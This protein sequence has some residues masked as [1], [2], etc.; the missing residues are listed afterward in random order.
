MI[1]IYAIVQVT[2]QGRG[3]PQVLGFGAAAAALMATF[4][5]VESR[6][7]NPIMPLRIL[8]LRGLIGASAVRGFLVTG[9][10]STF[11]L[12]TL[13]LEHVLHYGALQTGLAFLPWTLTVGVLSLGVTAR[14]VTRFGP[15]RVLVAGMLTVMLGLGLLG[16]TGVH[17]SF[18]PTL[19]FAY[20]AIG[21]GIGS[22]FMPLLSIAMADV[23]A[24]EAGLGSGITNMSQQVAGALGLAVL[25]TIATDRSQALE[26][27]HH[28]L[29]GALVS[30]Y[31]LAFAI[32]VVSV[33]VGLLTA[34]AVL[35]PPRAG[36]DAPPAVA[37]RPLG[38]V[39]D[40]P[41]PQLERQA[42]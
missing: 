5:V 38:P 10:Y 36:E 4:L 34:L 14:L 12:G 35:R 29:A 6:I 30:G 7:A 25:G 39:T 24:E 19:F 16:T 28:A 27:Q 26:A 40:D 21:L 9:M 22:A 23:P 11:F 2:G 18:F 33:A 37:V 42:A 15:M 8:R 17:T 13:Y 3:S 41:A 32:G 1:A 20:F 31:H